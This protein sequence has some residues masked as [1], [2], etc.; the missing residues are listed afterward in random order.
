MLNILHIISFIITTLYKAN[1]Y[2]ND[3]EPK[4]QRDSVVDKDNCVR[5]HTLCMGNF[6]CPQV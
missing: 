5:G 1:R 3:E 6:T 4:T 2:F